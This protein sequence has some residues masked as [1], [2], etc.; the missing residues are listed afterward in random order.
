MNKQA[1]I[2]DFDGTIADSEKTMMGIYEYLAKKNNRPPI[3]AKTKQMLR[4]GTTR[5]AIKWAGIRFWQIPGL[6]KVAR[7]EYKKRSSKVKI[8]PAMEQVITSLSQDYDLYILSTNSEKTVKSILRKNQFHP[9]MTILKGSSVFGKAKALK[10]LIKSG[11]YEAKECWMIGD[12]LRDIEAGNR[13]KLKTI[14]VTWGLQSEKGLSIA[15]PDYIVN[16]PKEI[17]KIIKG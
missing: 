3:D 8:F 9:K 1:V 4:D 13:V 6:L 16:Q 17:L 5:E 14:G 2:F 12:E 7:V 11:G 15:L 10:R